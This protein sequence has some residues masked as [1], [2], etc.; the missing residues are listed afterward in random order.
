MLLTVSEAKVFSNFRGKQRIREKLQQQTGQTK[1][2][3]KCIEF[4][5]GTS[6]LGLSCDV[7][8]NLIQ[9]CFMK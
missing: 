4:E 3:Y 7:S 8:Q 1:G 9:R 2:T 5:F 6:F